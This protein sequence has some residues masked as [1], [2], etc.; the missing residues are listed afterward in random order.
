[1][2]NRQQKFL[3]W[4]ER[5]FVDDENSDA[6]SEPF[7][8]GEREEETEDDSEYVLV[9]VERDIQNHHEPCGRDDENGEVANKQKEGK[10]ARVL[11][12]KDVET[13]TSTVP[14]Q[15]GDDEQVEEAKNVDRDGKSADE[16]V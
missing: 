13:Q 5:E 15:I 14:V 4:Y 1:M 16:G 11:E 2:S 6:S 3:N 9:H 12:M 10:E 7:D 8:D